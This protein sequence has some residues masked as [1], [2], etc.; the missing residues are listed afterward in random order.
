MPSTS[1]SS[2]AQADD[3]LGDINDLP[4]RPPTPSEH[5][6]LDEL[7]D[8]RIRSLIIGMSNRFPLFSQALF[9]WQD[10]CALIEDL[11]RELKIENLKLSATLAKGRK[12][13]L[14]VP[15]ATQAHEAEIAK[16]AR[17]FIIVTPLV[18][19]SII[20]KTGRPSIDPRSPQRF[21]SM[22]AFK[23]GTIAEIF[24]IFPEGSKVIP[25][26]GMSDWFSEKF[27]HYHKDQKC[28][29]VATLKLAMPIVFP[30]VSAAAWL[31]PEV[32]K[33]D[34]ECIRLRANGL[35]AAFLY[36]PG[37]EGIQSFA[38]RNP[39]LPQLLR[40]ALFNMSSLKPNARPLATSNGVKWG[41]CQ[42]EAEMIATMCTIAMHHLSYDRQFQAEG[43]HSGFRYM[44]FYQNVLKSLIT[45]QHT[46]R[47][48][49][50]KELWNK[51]A[52]D[53]VLPANVN[54]P[55]VAD[56]DADEEDNRRFFE[57]WDND[58]MEEDGF[59]DD[60]LQE[61]GV[62]VHS[63]RLNDVETEP[64]EIRQAILPPSLSRAGASHNVTQPEHNLPPVFTPIS[65]AATPPCTVSARLASLP[66]HSGEPSAE[67]QET[68]AAEE[69]PVPAI[70][71]K[72][73]R[74]G[75]ATGAATGVKGSRGA[76][77]GT[78]RGRSRGDLE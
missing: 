63:L 19:F 53:G 18:E 50:I 47:V 51:V 66:A 77:R 15:I 72:S 25:I 22:A 60:D 20:H 46:P 26:I 28:K 54:N 35:H 61:V 8:V 31:S 70:S 13:V 69:A 78:R 29:L 55:V 49:A 39:N 36:P 68:L 40:A 62:G 27:Q 64:E 43:D 34:P 16:Y 3:L 74:K 58:D 11:Y 14:D 21:A 5:A 41:I 7:R 17:K 73:V 37:R 65:R 57:R 44:V 56:E 32:R 45:K 71:R 38:C 52:F 33:T 76:G 10:R 67:I 24:D 75:A 23:L 12:K 30:T 6:T 48:K 1:T 9:D 4:D 42:T 59:G 2:Q